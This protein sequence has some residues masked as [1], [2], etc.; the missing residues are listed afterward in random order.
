LEPSHAP[1]KEKCERFTTLSSGMSF[2]RTYLEFLLGFDL[3]K[4]IEFCERI[5]REDVTGTLYPQA[6]LTG[7]PRR[8]FRVP[9]NHQSLDKFRICLEDTF[10]ANRDY[11]KSEEMVF[12]YGC[13]I[14][15]RNQ[16]IDETILAAQRVSDDGVLKKITILEDSLTEETDLQKEVFF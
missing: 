15:N 13:N 11:C 12:N 10:L 6:Y 9:L 3:E 1:Q 8:F 14:S 16:I 4:A 5:C 7:I 2:F